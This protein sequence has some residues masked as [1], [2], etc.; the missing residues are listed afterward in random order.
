MDAGLRRLANEKVIS[1]VFLV[2]IFL[3]RDLS[4][5]L[6]SGKNCLKGGKGGKIYL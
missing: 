4:R 2:L 6:V 3:S 5:I 1:F